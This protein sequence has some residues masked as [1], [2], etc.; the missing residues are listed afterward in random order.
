MAL[1]L[2]LVSLVTGLGFDLPSGAEIS[3]WVHSGQSW[4]QARIDDVSG[5]RLVATRRAADTEFSGIVDGMAASFTADL[6]GNDVPKSRRGVAFEPIPVPD[7]LETG[8]AFALNRDQEGRGFTPVPPVVA[9]LPSAV[10]ETEPT[11]M[12]RASRFAL[13]VRLTRQAAQEW[14]G[15]LT[16]IDGGSVRR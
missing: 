14:A 6:A 7:D 13:A 15:L 11:I 12:R 9:V 16:D 4:I 1:R 10:A 2:I 5:A 3:T 8:V